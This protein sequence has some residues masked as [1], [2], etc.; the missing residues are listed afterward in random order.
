[1][2]I[3]LDNSIFCSLFAG[4]TNTDNA[5]TSFAYPGQ[6]LSANQSVIAG[7]VNMTLNNANAVTS[8]LVNFGN[9]ETQ[10]RLVDG[11]LQRTI[12]GPSYDI[13]I[14]TKYTSATN[15]QIT[16]IIADDTGLSNPIPAINFSFRASVYAAPF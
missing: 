14:T 4:F 11:Y 5:T 16:I 2:T 1:M 12:G 8:L 3:N 7:T 15:L 13:I 6:T 9:I 10:W